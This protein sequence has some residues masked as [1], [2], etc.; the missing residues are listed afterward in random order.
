MIAWP[1]LRTCDFTFA[2]LITSIQSDEARHAQIGTIS[3]P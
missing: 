3:R 2:N 1:T